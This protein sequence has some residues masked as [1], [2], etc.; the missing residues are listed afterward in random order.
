[1]YARDRFKLRKLNIGDLA[2]TNKHCIQLKNNKQ[3]P[4]Q[5]A[6]Q[7]IKAVIKSYYHIISPILMLNSQTK[8]QVCVLI[9]HFESHFKS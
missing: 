5:Q 6:F 4:N 3:I 7:D 9:I 1:M 8:I 2:S